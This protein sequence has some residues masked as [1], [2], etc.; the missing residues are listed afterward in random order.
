MKICTYLSC[1]FT[2]FGVVVQMIRRHIDIYVCV[3]ICVGG[4]VKSSLTPRLT[5]S[6][7][8]SK[9][10]QC[11]YSLPTWPCVGVALSLSLFLFLSTSPLGLL[12]PVYL[13]CQLESKSLSP[14]IPR[15]AH[16]M[17]SRHGRHFCVSF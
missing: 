8:F 6:A 12:V 11:F 14:S 7:C 5:L 17:T 9:F 15:C 4:C 1:L 10:R 13:H 16:D 2:Y 3:C